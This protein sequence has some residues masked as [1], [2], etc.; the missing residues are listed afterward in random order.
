MTISRWQVFWGGTLIIFGALFL[1]SNLQILP[2][3]AGDVFRFGWPLFLVL[4]GVLIL[5]PGARGDDWHWTPGMGA[6]KRE[7]I[8]DGKEIRDLD[9]SHGLGDYY[10][11]LAHAVF[12]G[13]ARVKASH[14]LGDLK[15]RV[16]GK[17]SVK[18]K[19]TVGIGSVKVFGEEGDGVG[20]SIEKKSL[21]FD[22]AT[23][24]LELEATLGIGDLA[25]IGSE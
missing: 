19:A 1:L 11:D 13:S 2:L 18:V 4:L 20:A 6:G 21:D 10:I 7:E 15:I 17:L 14:G 24:R 9:L 5:M 3:G 16:P 12:P 25:V 23:S 8:F 22:R